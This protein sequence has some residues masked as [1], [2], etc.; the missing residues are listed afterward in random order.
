VAGQEN[1]FE[2]QR[3]VEVQYTPAEQPLDPRDLAAAQPLK[4][5]DTLRLSDVGDAI[6][7]LYATGRYT[8]IQVEA[9]HAPGGVILRFVTK[10]RWF[11]GHVGAEGAVSQPPNRGQITNGTQLS[12]GQPFEEKSVKA[13]EDTVS[14]LFESNGLYEA[15]VRSEI[16]REPSIQQLNF[17]FVVHAGKRARYERPEIQGNKLLS[18]DAIIRATGWRIRLI[19]WYRSV[20]ESRTRNGLAGILKA[21]EK[22]D[23]LMATA[24]I[25]NLD[26]DS[27]RRR[28]KPTVEVDAGPKVEIKALEADVSKGTLKK[29]IPVYDE[30]RVDQDLLVEGARNLRDYFQNQGYYDVNV[31][32]RQRQEGPEN[33]VIEYIIS[34]GQRYKLVE[35]KLE[36]NRYFNNETIRERMFLEPASWRLRHGRY[37]EAMRNKDEEN[38]ANLYRSNGFRD[39]RATSVVDR[40]Y[41]GKTGDI[42]VTMRISEG[43]QW[44]VDHIHINGVTHFD[45]DEI[46]SLLSSL[47]GQP[48]SEYNVAIDRST[49]LSRYYSAGFPDARF[50]WR[51]VPSQEPH[52]VNLEYVVREGQRQFVRDVLVTGIKHTRPELV[53]N[54]ITLQ[55]GDPLSLMAMTDGQKA[56]Y[57]L[58]VFAKV[59]TAVQNPDGR[60][61]YKHVLY[62]IEEA[63]R[64]T[65]NVGVGAEVGKLGG[66]TTSLSAPIGGNGFSP[67]VSLDLSRLNFLGRGHFVTLRGRVS[68]LDKRASF[69]YVAPRL[70]DVAGQDITFTALW[71][72]SNNVRT[73]SSRREEGSIQISRQFSR[74]T[75]G[76][77]RYTY[78][79]VSTSNVVIPALLVPALL[80]PVRLGLLSANLAEDKRDNPA[81]ARRGVYNTA[82]ISLAS[83]AFGSQRSFLRSLFRN[84]TYHP[85]SRYWTLA[86]ETTFGLIFPFNVPA[87]LDRNDAVPLPERFFGGGN[88]SNRGFPENQ[89]GPRDIGTPAGPGAPATQPTGFP[90]GGNAVLFNTVELRFPLIGENIGGVLFHDAGNVYRSVGDISFRASQRDPK[91]FNYMVHAVGFGLRY[92]T[93]VGP[94]RVDLAYSINPPSFYGFKGSVADL[95][96]CNPNLPP[97]QLPSQCQVVKQNVG[98]FQFFFSIGQTF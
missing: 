90:L 76:L 51:P 73:F 7:S 5:G 79:R 94:V 65:L 54:N 50:R 31:D 98:H 1:R 25:T 93:P 57:N 62:D 47:P 75:T 11:I 3:I 28:V 49:I 26:Y 29:Y 53:D 43:P 10:E 32:F 40:S 77:F 37:S 61:Q 48:Y 41:K 70:H 13:A 81:D 83:S 97:D 56:L 87:G 55:K 52:H 72:T 44:F 35:V 58:G 24:R 89:A 96:Q 42:A 21:Y 9:D 69:N 19:G 95:L 4:A 78:R 46:R 6:D 23:R 2:G 17:T 91:D 45:K 18:D 8:D 80:Q 38:I 59:E 15:K 82:D 66:T 22:Q 39:V 84:A 67:R 63:K 86:R 30:R 33:V 27:R 20:T 64:Y 36:G 71:E 12:L 60:E 92:K 88:V 85:I 74:A 34:R 68:T 14:R 16:L